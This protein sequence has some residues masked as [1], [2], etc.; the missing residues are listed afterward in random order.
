[1]PAPW[2]S[3]TRSGILIGKAADHKLPMNNQNG[4]SM[5]YNASPY[6]RTQPGK[7]SH[8]AL[9]L[10]LAFG[11]L[12][13]LPDAAATDIDTGNP[14]LKLRWDN[15]VKYSAAF[16][17]KKRS[18]ELVDGSNATNGDDGD[19]N[20]SRGLV[21]NRVDLLSEIDLTYKRFGARVSGAA[22]YDSVYNRRTD[23]DSPFTYNALSVPHTEFTEA[24]RKLH[25]RKGEL[26]EAFVFANAEVGGLP[27]SVRAGRHALVYGETLF[28]GMNGIAAA[29]Q[30]IDVLKGQSVPNT[31][32][33]E[34]IR[35]VGQVSGEIQLSSNLTFGAYY[36]YEWEKNRLPGSGSYFSSG[37]NIGPGRESLILGPPPAPRARYLG[38]VD[39]SD[40]GQGGI[41]LKWSPAGSDVD[42]GF[43]AA[44]YHSKS[45]D[46]VMS[47]APTPTGPA[48]AG[49]RYLYHEGIR[50]YGISASRTFGE[51]NVSAEVS[52]RHNSPLSH[53]GSTDLYGIVPAQFG[54][55]TAPSDN[56]DNTVYPLGRTAHLNI[57]TLAALA[58]NFISPEST[59]LG[60]LAWN[61]VTSITSHADHLDPNAT[62]DAWGMRVVYTPTFRQFRPGLDIDVPVG[63][64]YT[65]KGTS[66]VFGSVF[67]PDKGGDISIGIAGRYE[68]TWHFSLGITHYYGGAAPTAIPGNGGAVYTYKQALK[69]RDF[70]SVSLRRTF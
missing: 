15:T 46:I 67:G 37:D 21:S 45:M 23:N 27:V 32:F 59:L 2:P 31:P 41:Q 12:L 58:P 43:Y 62:R 18:A 40:S 69:D 68:D 35:P 26:L 39:A 54:G 6:D 34:L 60:E 30:P 64:G 14:D 1:M 24:T 19:R 11:A 57:S 55:P 70:A 56:R 9:L 66:A 5:T 61:R 28:Y 44:R 20:F 7:A 8:A 53:A 17:L 50:T 3:L 42:L 16:R 49:F 10:T 4:D 13:T 47:M 33:K 48:P 29:Q 65:P 22:W 36:Q 38:D 63:I 25:G 52:V 51:F